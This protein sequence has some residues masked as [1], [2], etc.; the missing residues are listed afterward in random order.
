MINREFRINNFDLLRIFAATQVVFLHS[1]THLKIPFPLWFQV[2]EKFPGVP[3]FFVMSGFLISASWERNTDFKNYFKNRVLRIYPA[4][5]VCIILTVVVI[6]LVGHVN[7]F[8]RPGLMWFLSQ[9][10]GI[11]YTPAFL[12]SYGFGSYNGSLWTI[13]IELQFYLVLPVIYFLAYKTTRV[14]KNR[15][16]IITGLFFLSIV[17]AYIILAYYSPL[18]LKFETKLQK[19]TRYTFLPNVYLFLLGICLQRFK[20]YQSKLFYGKGIYW[21]ILF[22]LCNYLL[23]DTIFFN[24]CLKI[25]LGITTISLAYTLS[26]VAQKLLKGNDISYGVY[27]YHGLILGVFVQYKLFGNSANVL[28]VLSLAYILAFLSWR[29]I[30]KPF[31]KIKSKTIHR[32]SEK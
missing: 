13:P 4:L 24:M 22:L 8:S 12:S 2:L 25:L 32:V 17:I 7:F 9:S 3:M 1:F 6:S 23:P 21:V 30:E 28:V 20:V 26:G 29:L 27:I 16:L 31:L 11:I 10:V 19:I 14:E 18:E 15:T 5:W